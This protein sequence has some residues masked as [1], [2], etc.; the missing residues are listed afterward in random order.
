MKRARLRVMQHTIAEYVNVERFS[1]VKHE[2]VHGRILAMGGG[3]INHALLGGQVI[4][5]LSP[6]L[7]GTE[8]KMYNSEL[9]FRIPDE[10]VI[11]YPDAS[12]ICGSAQTDKDD[13][14][15]AAN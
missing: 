13:H 12:I 7:R 14:L 11:V 9:R 3:T 5:D 4:G 1:N 15:A 10:D 6:Q 2:F 8:C